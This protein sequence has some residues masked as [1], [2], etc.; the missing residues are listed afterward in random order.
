MVVP[1]DPADYHF[2]IN[3]K[4]DGDNIIVFQIGI[5]DPRA[6]G[7]TFKADDQI[8]QGGP[9]GD[10]DGLVVVDVQDNFF[11]K[12]EGIVLTLFKSQEMVVLQLIHIKDFLC[13]QGMVLGHKYVK[14]GFNQ[15]VERQVVILQEFEKIR[16]VELAQVDDPDFALPSRDI[17]DDRKGLL[18]TQMILAFQMISNTYSLDES[19]DYEG[20]MLGGNRPSGA[21]PGP[22]GEMVFYKRC[23]LED[24]LGAI[25]EL[26]ALGRERQSLT[27]T[28]EYRYAKF[29]FEILDGFGKRRL[30][31]KQLPG[32]SGH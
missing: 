10:I 9:V 3:F 27:R 16:A 22:R 24:D 8:K 17:L 1:A 25:Q 14:P 2:L 12:I 15:V 13:G 21:G 29:L 32:R 18:L 11:A 31:D 26:L 6:D 28:D 7:V 4:P 30:A 5:Q 20:V 19:L 23:L